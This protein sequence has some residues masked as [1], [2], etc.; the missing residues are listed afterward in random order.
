MIKALVPDLYVTVV[1][2]AIQVFGAMGM[3][4]D[5]PLAD[6]YT[7]ARCLRIADGPDEVHLQTIAQLELKQGSHY[8]DGV[9]PHFNV[10]VHD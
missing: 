1:D 6:H 4:P 8:R 9:M 2:R 5:T 3:T 10:S 7:M